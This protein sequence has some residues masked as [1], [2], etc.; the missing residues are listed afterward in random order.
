M[1]TVWPSYFYITI[2]YNGYQGRSVLQGNAKKCQCQRWLCSKLAPV[3]MLGY[4][5]PR[6]SPVNVLQQAAHTDGRDA[7]HLDAHSALTVPTRTNRPHPQHGTRWSVWEASG[8]P[9]PLSP[10][11]RANSW[12]PAHPCGCLPG[13]GTPK[14]HRGL[15]P[16]GVPPLARPPSAHVSR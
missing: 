9:H 2:K 10:P 5:A 15:Y 12:R 6:S 11:G 1:H 7:H 8:A 13:R 3:T 14:S 16:T 4:S